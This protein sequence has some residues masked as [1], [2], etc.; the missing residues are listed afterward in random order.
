[1]D[2]PWMIAVPAPALLVLALSVIVLLVFAEQGRRE[3]KRQDAIVSDLTVRLMRVQL[4]RYNAGFA[5]GA[6][7]ERGMLYTAATKAAHE[8]R[9]IL[10]ALR[11]AGQPVLN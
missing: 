8:Q 3:V 10:L 6:R 4:E 7:H 2:N 1:M 11:E 5:N 9:D